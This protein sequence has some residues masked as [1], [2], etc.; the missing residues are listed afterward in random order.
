MR[1]S[2][3]EGLRWLRQAEHD[4]AFGRLAVREGFYAQACFVAQQTAEKAA[5]AGKKE[6]I[7]RRDLLLADDGGHVACSG[8]SGCAGSRFSSCQAN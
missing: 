5:K 2:H 8:C 4:L 3:G 1:D 6:D 7:A